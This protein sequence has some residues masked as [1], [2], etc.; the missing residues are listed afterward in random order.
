MDHKFFDAYGYL[1]FE[2]FFSELQL[3]GVNES[4]SHL[5]QS[6]AVD[7]YRDRLGKLRRMENFTYKVP[8][9]VALNNVIS[10]FLSELTDEK[11]ILFKDKVNFKP[12]GGEGFY[13][14]YDGIFQFSQVN[15]IIKDG[16]YEYADEFINVLIA[17]DDFTIENGALFVAEKHRG[18]F[19]DLIQNTKLNGTP[20]LTD[21]AVKKCEFFPAL[22][23][24]GGLVV[25]L[26]TCPH[27]SEPNLSNSSRGSL[28]WTYNRESVGNFYDVYFADKRLSTNKLKSLSGDLR[29]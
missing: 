11:W 3:E 23:R 18:S 22:I 1:I 15:G 6:L 4:L 25:F 21:D 29:S 14:H 20:D 10:D 26:N 2:S 13:P 16:W 27:R 9:L 12:A 8:E 19:S 17:L 28:Y 7:L 5:E 24:R